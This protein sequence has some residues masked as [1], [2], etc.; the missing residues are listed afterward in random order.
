MIIIIIFIIIVV[1]IVIVI[2]IIVIVIVIIIVITVIVVIIIVIIF[3]VIDHGV[4]SFH[5][6]V[7]LQVSHID[8]T[9]E[10]PCGHGTVICFTIYCGDDVDFRGN[11]D[12]G[13]RQNMLFVDTMLSPG[14][15]VGSFC[16]NASC[17]L[18]C[19]CHGRVLALY[20]S[21]IQML[22]PLCP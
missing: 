7:T 15:E 21:L 4:L 6:Y 14:M 10:S 19:H 16:R 3:V 20:K 11:P 9:K 8:V 12:D 18:P 22:L 2:S 1:I 13:E 17:A 5:V